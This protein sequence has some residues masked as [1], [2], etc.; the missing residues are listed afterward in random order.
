MHQELA[1]E[2]PELPQGSKSNATGEQMQL[3]LAVPTHY[4]Q[5]Q[6][7]E[8]QTAG[9]RYQENLSTDMPPDEP[10]TD[11]NFTLSGA[12]TPAQD[13]PDTDI[14]Q[15]EAEDLESELNILL[16]IDDPDLSPIMVA[17]PVMN[18]E[19]ADTIP[20]QDLPTDQPER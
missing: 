5:K 8:T 4:R 6:I 3:P 11:D 20:M 13:E 12:G 9:H 16:T 7:Y 19:P 15:M 17:D 1:N 14:S 2:L 10:L 18:P